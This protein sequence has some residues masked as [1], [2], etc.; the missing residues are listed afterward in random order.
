MLGFSIGFRAL[1]SSQLAMDVLGQNITN[2]ATKGYTRKDLHFGATSP[3]QVGR[4]GFFGTGVQISSVRSMRDSVLEGRLRSEQQLMGQLNAESLLLRNMEQFLGEPGEGALSGK[5]SQFFNSLSGLTSSPLDSALHREL[6]QGSEAIALGFRQQSTS[7]ESLAEDARSSIRSDVQTVNS[8][9][10]QLAQNNKAIGKTAHQAGPEGELLDQQGRLLLELSDYANLQVVQRDR[11]TID[12]LLDGQLLVSGDRS[13]GLEVKFPGTGEI[14]FST[15]TGNR[16]NV[17]EGRLAGHTRIVQ[18]VLGGRTGQL[19]DVARALIR[20]INRLHSTSVP[21]GGPYSSL[22]AGVALQSITSN[23]A[24][25]PLAELGLPFQPSAGRVIV[26][27]VEEATGRVDQ[28][29]LV[30]NPATMTMADFAGLL[31]SVPHLSVSVDSVG[32]LHINAEQGFGFEFSP[33]VDPNPNDAGTFGA[34]EAL[35]V[36]DAGPYALANGNQISI[37]VDGGAP[38]T[39][40]F[41]NADFVDITKATAE[42]VAAVI[43][44]QVA[45]VT[46]ATEGGRL[47]V[48]SNTGGAAS[49]LQ[50]ADVSGS[51]TSQLGLSTALEVGS[52]HAVEVTL[53]GVPSNFDVNGRVEVRANGTGTIGLTPGLQLEVFDDNGFLVSTLDVGDTYVPGEPLEVLPGVQVTLSA[54]EITAASGDRFEFLVTDDSDTTDLLMSLELGTLFTGSSAADIAV[55]DRVS[56]DP[57]FLAGSLSGIAGDNSGFLAML[58]LQDQTLT[59][60]RSRSI[61]QGYG[62]LVASIGL[63]VQT[64]ESSQQAQDLV[65]QT[66]QARRAEISGVNLDEELLKLTQM[67]QLFQAAGRYLQVVSETTDTLVNLV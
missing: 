50:M 14:E 44:A 13:I 48:R 42:E 56:Q 9:A 31:D 10:Q 21:V 38:Q 18:D 33:R 36:G 29:E 27:V 41:Q 32:R 39:V 51:P 28:Q 35:L 16:L 53:Q 5:L 11:G 12:V 1:Q 66:L 63:D 23:F 57:S 4:L 24:N 26:N 58:A 8:L 49:S 43:N 59:E 22:S 17:T 40:T 62:D 67:E 65:V 37:A 61:S 30:V 15:A 60:L 7:M 47:I 64:T 45:G 2:F 46:A 25:L 54:G 19:D 20:E 34:A 55:T 52:D 3:I 6:V